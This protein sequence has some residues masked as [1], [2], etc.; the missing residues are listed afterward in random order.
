MGYSPERWVRTTIQET[1][2]DFHLREELR[3]I[4]AVHETRL[5]YYQETKL[6]N[7]VNSDKFAISALEGDDAADTD[8]PLTV[9][10]IVSHG[11]PS[12][13][14][15]QRWD[16]VG[17]TA[18][19]EAVLTRRQQNGVIF[20]RSLLRQGKFNEGAEINK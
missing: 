7:Y 19:N 9:A 12:S 5:N 15:S 14:E 4:A 17:T 20:V 10:D 18:A 16:L 13:R 8:H 1:K 11:D 6:I 3:S 2:T